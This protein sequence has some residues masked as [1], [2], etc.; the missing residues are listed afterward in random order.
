MQQDGSIQHYEFLADE[1]ELP[2]ELIKF[3]EAL[4]GKSGTF[5]S[6][7]ASFE[8][9]RNKEMIEILPQYENYLT[10]MNNNMFDLEDIFK[11]DYVDYKF[12]GSTSIKKILPVLLPELSYDTLKVQNG[13]MALD[14]WGR[15]VLDDDFDED[16]EEVRKNLLAY[17]ELDTLAMLELYKKLKKY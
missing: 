13:T 5:I 14:V 1:L 2:A 4:T 3:M 9:S 17:C 12:N 10:Y 8:I 7:H 15:L 11:T 16:K 6:W